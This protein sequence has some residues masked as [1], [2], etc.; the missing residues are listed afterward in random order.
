MAKSIPFQVVNRSLSRVCLLECLHLWDTYS[1]FKVS[2]M[3]D[4][5]FQMESVLNLKVK[6]SILKFHKIKLADGF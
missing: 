5:G 1:V 6:D 2:L 4:L 3:D